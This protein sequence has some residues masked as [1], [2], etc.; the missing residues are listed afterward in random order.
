[1]ITASDADMTPLK[2]HVS[3]GYSRQ[4]PDNATRER[5]ADTGVYIIL[6]EDQVDAGC[7]VTFQWYL[8]EHGIDC[9]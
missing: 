8:K 2:D 3:S 9:W 1:M 4:N 7:C 6:S 5:G